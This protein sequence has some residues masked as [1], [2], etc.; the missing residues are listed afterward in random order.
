[1]TQPTAEAAYA[2]LL[3]VL[4]ERFEIP[5]ASLTPQ[6]SVTELALDSMELV[7]L[8][9]IMEIDVD[10]LPAGAD[11]TLGGLAAE[12]RALPGPAHGTGRATG[13]A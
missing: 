4:D 7:E 8:A 5:T 6:T 2:R 10:R 1:M 13:S 12:L 3:E 9:V 11:V